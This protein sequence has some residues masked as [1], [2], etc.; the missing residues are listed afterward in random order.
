MIYIISSNH[1]FRLYNE[2]DVFDIITFLGMVEDR[3]RTL[4]SDPRGRIVSPVR[5]W[6]LKGCDVNKDI[7]IDWVAELTLPDLQI[8]FID[9]A[10]RAYV[11][12]MGNDV[13]YRVEWSLVP[14]KPVKQALENIRKE[15]KID[16][17]SLIECFVTF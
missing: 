8:P 14:N 4:L 6:I 17:E 15:V 16:R 7:E 11:K 12:P 13:F 5:H 1:P 2:Q 10:L 9:K 3:F